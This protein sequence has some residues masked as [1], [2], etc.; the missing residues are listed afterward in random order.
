MISA[1]IILEAAR[2]L[3]VRAAIDI[4]KDAHQKVKELQEKETSQLSSYVLGKILENY[5]AAIKDRSAMCADTGL[6]Q[7]SVIMRP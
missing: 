4:P 2:E 7:R 1:N 5:D 6:P 3:N